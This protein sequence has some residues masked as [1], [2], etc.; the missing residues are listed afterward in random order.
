MREISMELKL[1]VIKLFLT[2]LTFN[3]IATQLPVSNCEVVPKIW[4]GC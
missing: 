4:T 2:G 3:E 1:R